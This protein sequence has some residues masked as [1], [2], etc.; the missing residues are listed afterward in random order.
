M[1]IERRFFN[2]QNHFFNRFSLGPL[3]SLLLFGVVF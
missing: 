2:I 1:A 3:F